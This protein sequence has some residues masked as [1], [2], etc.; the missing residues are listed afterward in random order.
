MNEIDFFDI[1]DESRKGRLSLSFSENRDVYQASS[2]NFTETFFIN[3]SNN[4][5]A[6]GGK[7]DVFMM[8]ESSGKRNRFES[9]AGADTLTLSLGP[10][11]EIKGRLHLESADDDLLVIRGQNKL[12]SRLRSDKDG[13]FYDIQYPGARM[14]AYVDGK[15][16]SL[17]IET[18]FATDVT[19]LLE[20]GA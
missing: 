12:K 15:N 2:R 19:D 14:S 13:C 16:A 3:T 20:I 18:D 6:S 11:S 10:K 5:I 9:R 4:K 8:T 7:R 17:Y 1:L